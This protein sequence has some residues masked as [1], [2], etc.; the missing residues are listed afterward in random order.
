[1]IAKLFKTVSKAEEIHIKNH[2]QALKKI[3]N[4]PHT[5]QSIIS[6]KDLNLTIES[7]ST[8]KNL[9]DA[10]T[11]ETYEFKNMYKKYI[12]NAKKKDIYLAE[13]SFDLARKAERVHSELFTKYLKLLEKGKVIEQI[14]IFLCIICGNV[15]LDQAPLICPNCDHY[16]QFFELI[17]L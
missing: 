1:M 13:F 16:Q 10:I 3:T 7:K 12:R 15:E 2:L 17:K 14:P 9:M 6:S 5:L 11:G 8:R 4:K